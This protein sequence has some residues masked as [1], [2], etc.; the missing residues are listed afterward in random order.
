VDVKPANFVRHIEQGSG[1]GHEKL[2]NSEDT[3][4]GAVQDTSATILAGRKNVGVIHC[5]DAAPFIRVHP[6]IEC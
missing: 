6:S 2:T 3:K 4:H 1:E 5:V